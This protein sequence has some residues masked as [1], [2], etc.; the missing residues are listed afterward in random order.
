MAKHFLWGPL[1][2][3]PSKD[4]AELQELRY[5]S[6][7]EA[8]GEYILGGPLCLANHSCSSSLRFTQPQ[9]MSLEEFAGVSA[10]YVRA[11]AEVS[12]QEGDE[13]L[14]K[15]VGEKDAFFQEGKCKCGTCSLPMRGSL[16]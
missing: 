1:W 13:V 5:P 7:F 15:Y 16:E 9:K 3:I 6:L 8:R 2:E 10:V 4:S 11:T 12:F 14:V